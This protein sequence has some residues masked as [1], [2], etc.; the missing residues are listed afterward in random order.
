MV[1]QERRDIRKGNLEF[2]HHLLP[3]VNL[4]Q[5]QHSFC[6]K[7]LSCMVQ[8]MECFTTSNILC[9][10][11]VRLNYVLSNKWIKRP[12]IKLYSPYF[13][14]S[15]IIQNLLQGYSVPQDLHEFEKTSFI[16]STHYVWY[17]ECKECKKE[18]PLKEL[19]IEPMMQLSH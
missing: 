15:L 9:N 1:C 7:L 11:I 8:G 2:L 14:L 19:A 16:D 4:T 5:T 6:S 12:N 18:R 17:W 3:Q 13:K 10:I